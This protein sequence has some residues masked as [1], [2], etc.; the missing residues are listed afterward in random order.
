ML[1]D[2]DALL[3]DLDGTLVDS[4]WIWSDIDIAYLNRYNVTLPDNMQMQIEGMS[5]TE[6]AVFFKEKFAIPDDIETIKRDWNM[7]AWE[8][9][10]KEVPMKPG[11]VEFLKYAC[12]KGLKMGIATSNSV[13]LVKQIAKVHGL[14]DFFSVIKTSCEAAKGKPAPDIYLLVANALNAEPERCLV[15]EDIVPGIIAGKSAGMKV[16]GVEDAYSAP[17]RDEKIRLADYYIYHYDEILR[18]T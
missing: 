3:F 17:T 12:E 10:T 5:F 9:Y 6:T 18:V 16:C 2:I 4:M 14:N 1:K 15:F 11:A 13:E 8:K 7:M